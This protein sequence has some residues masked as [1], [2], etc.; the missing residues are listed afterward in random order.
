MPNQTKS[1]LNVTFE[2]TLLLGAR[3]IIDVI[4]EIRAML[5][6]SRLRTRKQKLHD[7]TLK[8]YKNI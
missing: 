5:R 6:A 2:D 7:I 8:K 3:E 4:S 1:N